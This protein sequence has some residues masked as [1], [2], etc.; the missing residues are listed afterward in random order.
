MGTPAP[1]ARIRTTRPTRRSVRARVVIGF[2]AAVACVPIVGAS[3]PAQPGTEQVGPAQ[4]VPDEVVLMLANGRTVQGLLVGQDRETLTLRVAGVDTPIRRSSIQG[5]RT[6][7]PI[8]ERY[9][10]MRDAI[11]PDDTASLVLLAAWLRDREMY[12]E[13]LAEIE[14]VVRLEP[15]NS[16][17][18][19]LERWLRAQVALEEGRA[20]ADRGRDD[21]QGESRPPAS[22][23]REPRDRPE[24]SARTRF[25][26]LTPE[27]I[28]V[29]RVY[30][31]DLDDPP[32]MRVNRDVVEEL[33]RAY[34]G[35]SEI[36]A[37]QAGRER[38][39][40]SDASEVLQLMFSLR[41]RSFYPRVQVLEDPP[42]I[43]MFRDDVHGTGGWLTNACASSRCHGGEHA[44]RLYLN[45][46]RINS[47][48]TVYT[49]LLILD[50][51]RLESGAPLIDYARP[52]RSPLLHMAL[53]RDVSLYPHP[54]VP[55]R[56]GLGWRPVFRS[57]DDRGF[58]R[59]VAWIDAMYT[60][61]IAYPVEYE[62]PVPEPEAGEPGE[63]QTES[64]SDP[65]EPAAES[66]P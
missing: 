60:P 19:D 52:A 32:R 34:A 13:A 14:P 5:M 36:P 1:R 53:A 4:S 51:F 46:R 39:L 22:V 54:E 64:E 30:E 3:I 37:T 56:G 50:R 12:R 35:E 57:T 31:V 48:E 55:G 2:V 20:A 40:R 65:G 45:N 7:P 10:A 49:N 25:P 27:Q 6:L 63:T 59:A 28:N 58:E 43:A 9:R 18:R 17:A 38:L 24:P 44:G 42:A 26:T 41:A 47:D 29:M 61:R 62:A 21:D 8:V 23:A 16:E 11:E 15:F 33:I 66:G